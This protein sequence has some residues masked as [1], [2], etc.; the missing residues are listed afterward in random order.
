MD[1]G[2]FCRERP[3]GA[4]SPIG[5][6]LAVC[7]QLLFHL[8]RKPESPAGDGPSPHA[9]TQDA[10]TASPVE[11]ATTQTT[12]FGMV[13]MLCQIGGESRGAFVSAGASVIF[14]DAWRKASSGCGPDLAAQ[15][16]R[17][18][19]SD[20]S[21]I[22]KKPATRD[23]LGWIQSRT[24]QIVPNFISRIPAGIPTQS[25]P[26]ECRRPQF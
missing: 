8:P 12:V 22:R 26:T 7:S 14:I 19:N 15:G 3:R 2:P 4:V 10:P 5:G 23:C 13:P 9:A 6:S 16:R 11:S 18:L 25:V 20:E 1:R 17:D 24:I 21:E